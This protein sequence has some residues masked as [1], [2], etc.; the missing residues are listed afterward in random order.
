MIRSAM[1]PTDAYLSGIEW[2]S[3]TQDLSNPS[4]LKL[5]WAYHNGRHASRQ[6]DYK[7]TQSQRLH[8]ETSKKSINSQQKLVNSLKSW[9]FNQKP[10]LITKSRQ[11]SE[12]Y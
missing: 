8:L 12:Y 10:R 6:Q 1:I 5:E 3:Q 9:K 4:L 7:P 11:K 2:N